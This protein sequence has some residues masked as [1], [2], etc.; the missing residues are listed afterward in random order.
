MRAVYAVAIFTALAAMA[1][2]GSASSSTAAVQGGAS[3]STGSSAGVPGTNT[4]ATAS[5]G[6]P[7][8][9]PAIGLDS[10]K[11]ILGGNIGSPKITPDDPYPN[12]LYASDA[13]I[14][15]SVSITVFQGK[16][17][18]DGLFAQGQQQYN[19]T[20]S[21]PGVGDKAFADAEGRVILARKGDNS[22]VVVVAGE[23]FPGSATARTQQLGG[24]CSR[25][26][27]L[28]AG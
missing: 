17:A 6:Q 26:F 14:A 24:I 10:A 23:N 20:V 2:C 7:N 9:C 22:C 18:S 11:A 3:Q 1:A 25:G 19:A 5:N 15:S 27:T 21:V 12:C 4:G 13:S 8:V 16:T 28:V